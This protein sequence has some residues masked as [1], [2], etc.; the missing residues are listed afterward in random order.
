MREAPAV[1]KRDL[2]AVLSALVEAGVDHCGSVTFVIP[3]EGEMTVDAD[4]LSRFIAE[5]RGS[6]DSPRER[7][8]PTPLRARPFPTA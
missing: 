5:F 3:G 6:A 8:V 1:M 4:G 2:S 7:Q